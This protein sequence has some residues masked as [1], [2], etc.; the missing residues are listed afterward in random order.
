M[1]GAAGSS[2]STSRFEPDIELLLPKQ[3]NEIAR[4]NQEQNLPI[5]ANTIESIYM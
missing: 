3:K 1:S 5:V 4:T 2:G